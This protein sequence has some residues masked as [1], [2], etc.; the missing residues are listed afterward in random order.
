MYNSKAN[1]VL[2]RCKTHLKSVVTVDL[3]MSGVNEEKKTKKFWSDV[4]V[5]HKMSDVTVRQTI[6]L[7]SKYNITCL[8][9]IN[10]VH[11]QINLHLFFL[12]CF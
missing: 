2:C 4:T 3:T 11:L 10:I 7:M 6:S 9:C 5:K 1:Y 12:F 8:L